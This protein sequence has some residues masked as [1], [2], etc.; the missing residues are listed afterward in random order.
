MLISK[1]KSTTVNIEQR[2]FED[3]LTSYFP[4]IRTTKRAAGSPLTIEKILKIET[5]PAILADTFI[6]NAKNI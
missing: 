1:H 5:V 3:G 6:M 2:H 4:V